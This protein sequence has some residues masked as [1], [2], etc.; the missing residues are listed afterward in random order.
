MYFCIISKKIFFFLRNSHLT[1]KGPHVWCQGCGHGGHVMHMHEWFT[2]SV[3]C[4]AGCGHMCEFTWCSS[5]DTRTAELYHV[6]RTSGA[7]EQSMMVF[8]ALPRPPKGCPHC[9]DLFCT[10]INGL[11]L[12]QHE[13]TDFNPNTQAPSTQQLDAQMQAKVWHVASSK[14]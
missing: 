2:K 13:W 8:Q 12:L 7:R 14:F 1:V 11:M 5:R 3:W 9:T 6:M 4:P 10:G